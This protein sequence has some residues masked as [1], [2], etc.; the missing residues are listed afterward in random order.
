[1]SSHQYLFPSF[2]WQFFLLINF[3]QIFPSSQWPWPRQV[4]ALLSSQQPA[5]QPLCAH[6][7]DVKGIGCF[8][9]SVGHPSHSW[10]AGKEEKKVDNFSVLSSVASC[11]K[12]QMGSL[13][14]LDEILVLIFLFWGRQMLHSLGLLSMLYYLGVPSVILDLM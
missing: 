2:Y 8:T 5:S 9:L 13:F 14:L 11:R 6:A 4:K 10:Q 3:L 12:R 1:M 7:S